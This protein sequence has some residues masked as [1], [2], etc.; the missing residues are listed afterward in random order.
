MIKYTSDSFT[1]MLR[2]IGFH[3]TEIMPSYMSSCIDIDESFVAH[4]VIIRHLAILN[5]M[6]LIVKKKNLP[7]LSQG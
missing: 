1:T 5:N 4:S 6:K 2:V 3:F 7:W